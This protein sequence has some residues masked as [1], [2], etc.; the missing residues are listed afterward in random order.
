MIYFLVNN[1]YH[2]LD[3]YDHCN[4]IS[5]LDK[6]LIIIPHNFN[7]DN[8]KIS[9]K[10]NFTTIYRYKSPFRGWGFFNIFKIRRVC[11]Q[12]EK[13]LF[14][15]KNDVLFVYTEYEILNQY[16]IKIFK[17]K[18]A[19]IYVIEDGGLPTYLTFNIDND[20]SFSLKEMIKLFFVNRILKW[21]HVRFLKYN[22]I[23]F[24]QIEDKYLDG[25]LLY[26]KLTIRRNIN[27]YFILKDVEKLALDEE[28][29]IFL[30]ERI[31][32]Y[33][34]SK[35]EYLS[36][37]GDAL[38]KITGKF[39]KVYF[40]FHPREHEEDQLWQLH[41][42]N[43]YPV[44]IINDPKPFEV[45]LDNLKTRYVFSFLSAALLNSYFY[46]AIPVYIYHHYE[47]LRKNKIFCDIDKLL[48]SLGYRYIDVNYDNINEIGFQPGNG[49]DKEVE[50]KTFKEFLR[51]VYMCDDEALDPAGRCKGPV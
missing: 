5:D 13:E 33:Y 30:N 8:R 10:T 40:K 1:E 32:D 31:Y 46:G 26:F 12:I 48:M 44:E 37:L 21:D 28:S 15:C 23:I 51:C 7:Y 9:E 22:E 42:I 24:P 39:R 50:F 17:K 27:T 34:C 3:V 16:I 45:L 6:S 29:A 38:R 18:G 25:V 4:Q 47:I 20:G 41:V 36:L 14:I 49:N 19:M 35:E 11:Q 43:K 2:L